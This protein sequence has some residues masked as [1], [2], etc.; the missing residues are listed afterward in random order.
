MLEVGRLRWLKD[1]NSHG[2]HLWYVVNY[3][4]STRDLRKEK[5]ETGDWERKRVP[6]ESK[7]GDREIERGYWK[8]PDSEREDC[9]Y[10]SKKVIIAS[11]T[12]VYYR[13]KQF[14]FSIILW[15]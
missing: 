12:H 11:L 6:E 10:N 2:S 5:D 7:G 13:T 9:L 1:Q 3:Q 15:F 14:D 8:C 4:Q